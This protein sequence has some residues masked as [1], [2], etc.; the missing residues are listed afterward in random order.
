V[1]ARVP[2]EVKEGLLKLIDDAVAQGWAHQRACA[3]LEVADVRVHRWRAR[4]VDVGTLVDRAP[5]GNPV[6]RLLDWEVG[7]ILELIEQWGPVDRSHRK[8]A[9]RGSYTGKV[10]VA[11]STLRRVAEKH[12]VRL[13]EP[14]PRKPVALP[15]WPEFVSWEPNCIW[16]W[17]VTKFPRARRVCFAIVDVVSRRWIELVLS[18]E[19]SA[20]QVQLLFADAL[21]A[22]GL[23]D[24]LT[25]ERVDLA[26][27]DPARPILLAW[28]DRGP[29]MTA[30]STREFMALVAIWQYHGRPHTPT[31]QAHI[32]SFF[33]H[34]KSEWP[35][36]ERITDPAVLE[37]EL[38]RVRT[39]YNT[40]RL[41]AGIGYV[42]PNDEHYGCGPA[43]RRARVTGLREARRNRI[44]HNRRRNGQPPPGERR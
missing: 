27:D 37:A 16:M 30:Q 40:V 18:V 3:V 14:A 23:L 35:H 13:P 9:H 1:P 38:R 5:G 24:R 25:P 20:T 43:I 41:H 22:E 12:Q 8:L 21:Q 44:E 32:E 4:V 17:D 33:A 19:E 6:H 31:D 36:L 42:T 39:E 28:S 7:A 15:P 34:I 11:P 10:F 26:V 2:G 29:Q